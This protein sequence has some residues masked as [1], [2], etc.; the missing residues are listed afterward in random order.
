MR[1][2]NDI[3]K[4]VAECRIYQQNKYET[5]ASPGLLQPFFI[6]QQ[7]WSNVSIDF[8]VSLPLSKGK[9]IIMVMVDR[10]S[11]YAYLIALVHPYTIAT[12]AQKFLENIFKLHGM[13]KTIVSDRDCVFL[14][15][16]W[17]KFFKLRLSYACVLVTILRVLVKLR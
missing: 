5:I 15:A 4:W 1:T 6:P 16:F 2:K 7:V 3:K 11:K 9:S 17:R 13:P 8:V 12:L 10:L 14:S